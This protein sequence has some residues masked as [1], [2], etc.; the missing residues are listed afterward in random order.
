[1]NWIKMF[2]SISSQKNLQDLTNQLLKNIA[3][4]SIKYGIFNRNG[5]IELTMCQFQKFIAENPSDWN[6]DEIFQKFVKNAPLRL[7]Y[8]KNK[9]SD[10]LGSYNNIDSI[11]LYISPDFNEKIKNEVEEYNNG[12]FSTMPNFEK[13]N[14]RNLYVKLFF[15]FGSILLHELQHVYDNYVSDGRYI[16]IKKFDKYIDKKDKL[17]KLNIPAVDNEN[18]FDKRIDKN[19]KFYKERAYNHKRYMNLQHEINARF[20]QAMEKIHIW[21]L[22]DNWKYF[23]YP[24]NKIENDFRRNFSGWNLL[25]DNNKKRLKQRVYQFWSSSIEPKPIDLKKNIN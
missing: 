4:E 5:D 12:T 2:E 23:K 20:T 1:M 25:S 15:E 13:Y 18:T 19:D 7:I 9:V 6:S 8:F 11:V 16:N 21:G 17:N 14:D 10:I 22:D 24:F 3:K